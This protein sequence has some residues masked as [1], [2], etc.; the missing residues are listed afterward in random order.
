MNVR[1]WL[2][3]TALA[4]ALLLPQQVDAA[5]V[6]KDVTNERQNYV[7]EKLVSAD[8]IDDGDYFSPSSGMTRANMAEMLDR[9][10]DF[11]VNRP[12]L[13]FADVPKT[14]KNYDA[15]QALY[16]AG[17][18][19]GNAGNFNPDGIVKRA[20]VAKVLTN[21]LGLIPQQTTSFKDVPLSDANNEYIGALIAEGLTTGFEDG[22]FRPNQ[23][24]TKIQF[25]TFVYRALYGKEPSFTVSKQLTSN[26]AFAPTKI[27]AANYRIPFLETGSQT[28]IKYDKNGYGQSNGADGYPIVTQFS[29]NNIMIGVNYTDYIFY[30]LDLRGLTESK[31][32]KGVHYIYDGPLIESLPYIATVSF[33]ETVKTSS[34]TIKGATKIIYDYTTLDLRNEY[35]FKEGFGL[36]KHVSG[37]D[38]TWELTGY[39]LR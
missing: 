15:I 6:F 33:N 30:D 38:T 34:L 5:Q 14:H 10:Y 32:N 22:T 11:Y 28:H 18:V 1:K 35:Y 7:L 9:A 3:A 8:V 2:L 13:D 27:S 24:V 16:Q 4:G 39:K 29:K 31:E 23:Q 25:A 21:L 17:V 37:Q 26:L 20:H 36:I 12:A 19:D